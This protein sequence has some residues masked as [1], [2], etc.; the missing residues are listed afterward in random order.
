MANNTSGLFYNESANIQKC[1][2]KKDKRKVLH[3]NEPLDASNKSEPDVFEPNNL[4]C[5]DKDKL[6]D[7]LDVNLKESN[8]EVLNSASNIETVSEDIS[9]DI[10]FDTWVNVENFFEKYRDKIDLL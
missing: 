2:E 5:Q 10:V 9:I 4:N 3:T 1:N 7:K 6:I 8:N